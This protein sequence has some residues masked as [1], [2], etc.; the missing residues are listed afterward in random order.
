MLT[1]GPSPGLRTRLDSTGNALS[2]ALQ[3]MRGIRMWNT[4][5]EYLAWNR[6]MV[7]RLGSLSPC[8]T[9]AFAAGCAERVFQG[10]ELF[11]I[12]TG[13]GNRDRVRSI[14]DAVWRVVGAAEDLELTGVLEDLE[15]VVPHSADHQTPL[16]GC[17]I[18]CICCCEVAAR[19]CTNQA[20][21][22]AAASGSAMT[23]VLIPAVFS[24]SR[25]RFAGFGTTTQSDELCRIASRVRS[26]GCE[27]AEQQAAC[28]A[29]AGKTRLSRNEAEAQRIRACGAAH[30]FSILRG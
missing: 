24:V 8:G 6:R 26:I 23:S 14:L 2:V 12:V 22:G 7:V 20:C 11:S 10:Y 29:L 17:A 27:V 19:A 16:A 4:V 25:G 15:Q 30:D 21:A 13:W 5:D 18:E 28:A 3:W 1:F 9:A